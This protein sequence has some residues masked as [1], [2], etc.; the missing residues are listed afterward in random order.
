MNE[1]GSMQMNASVPPP[2]LNAMGTQWVRP[3]IDAF[4]LH[5]PFSSA[6]FCASY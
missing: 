5:T 3:D 4:S 6:R 2:L 1:K